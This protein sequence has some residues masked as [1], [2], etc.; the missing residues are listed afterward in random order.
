MPATAAPTAPH[1]EKLLAL[2]A[3][4]WGL[5][6]RVVRTRPLPT[7]GR[8]QGSASPRCLLERGDR[9]LSLRA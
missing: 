1:V 3:L 2:T 6:P 7:A 8:K 5:G 4:A 9:S